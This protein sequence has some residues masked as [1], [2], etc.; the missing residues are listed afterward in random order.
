MV[1]KFDEEMIRF[2]ESGVSITAGSRDAR[3]VPSMAR[4]L[5]CRVNADA[6]TLRLLLAASQCAQ[7]LLDC[8]TSDQL[9]VVFSQPSTHRT[10]QV[11]GDG[12]AE[13]PV[14]PGD[15]SIIEEHIRGFG[16]ELA[17]MGFNHGFSRAFFQWREDDVI[18]LQ[19]TARELY[20]QTPGPDAGRKL[21]G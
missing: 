12:V 21:A 13:V 15:G 1:L 10:L 18:A 2:F 19:F 17:P 5:G 8:K 11:K 4:V 3:C 14:E 7:L 6:G 16:E 20:D 9:A